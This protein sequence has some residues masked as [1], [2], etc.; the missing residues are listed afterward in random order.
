MR[1]VNQ[2]G[3]E[4]K[5][6]EYVDSLASCWHIIDIQEVAVNA[7][8]SDDDGDDGLADDAANDDDGYSSNSASSRKPF[9]TTCYIPAQFS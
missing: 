1:Q 9:L 7:A 4:G 3:S 5:K 2:G 6:G 8:N